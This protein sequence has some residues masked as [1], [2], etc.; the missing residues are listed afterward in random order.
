MDCP[1]QFVDSFPPARDDEPQSLRQD[2]ADELADHLECALRRQLITTPDEGRARAQVVGRFGDPQHL[3]RQL[4]LEAMQ[5]KIMSQRISLAVTILLA[6]VCLIAVGMMWYSMEHAQA[7][8]RELVEETRVTNR[9]LMERLEQLSVQVPSEKTATAATKSPDWNS[10]E[11]RLV[12]GENDGPPAEGFTVRLNRKR[13]KGG[14]NEIET[15]AEERSDPDGIANLGMVP[16]GKYVMCVMG[17][18]ASGEWLSTPVNVLPGSTQSLKIICPPSKLEKAGVAIRVDMPKDLRSKNP[19]LTL[20]LVLGPRNFSGSEWRSGFNGIEAYDALAI[21]IIAP[22]GSV[23]LTYQGIMSHSSNGEPL[24][25]LPLDS[26]GQDF[27]GPDERPLSLFNVD[28]YL[29]TIRIGS[30]IGS[31]STSIDST[32]DNAK[33]GMVAIKSEWH[34]LPEQKRIYPGT[35]LDYRIASRDLATL[36]KFTAA[37]EGN[38]EW[39]ILV[40][41][42]FWKQARADLERMQQASRVVPAKI[43]P[44]Y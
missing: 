29:R 4:W 15:V 28:H 17:G 27:A 36:Q 21:V 30:P 34:F 24:Q 25:M 13:S 33:P 14:S 18:S 10:V 3:A 2:I 23:G 32:H 43:L 12:L 11:V 8:A 26:T 9:L 19:Y 1:D 42:E 16:P 44:S 39:Q 41:D 31:I 22:D 38:S 37:A 40:P 7:T 6:A 5:E 35:F 20:E